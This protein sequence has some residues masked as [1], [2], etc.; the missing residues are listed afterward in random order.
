MMSI[1]MKR[2]EAL[3]WL[4]AG[5][6]LPA[7]PPALPDAYGDGTP[8]FLRLTDRP[9]QQAFRA[10]SCWLA[11]ALYVSQPSLPPEVSDCA[12]LLRFCFRE[13]LR[14]HDGAWARSLGLLELPP[15]G[16]VTPPRFPA[17]FLRDR[18]FRIR[19]G[20]FQERDI[21]DGAFRAFASARHLMLFN[22]HPAGRDL[23]LA[24]PG[25]LLFFEQLAGS[26]PFHSMLWTGDAAV[27]HTG[28]LRG[29]EGEIRRLTPAQLASHP[30]P[31]W[32]PLPGNQNFLGVYRWNILRDPT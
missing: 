15:I 13:S 30:E 5:R 7:G 19:P 1:L 2:R 31:R 25:D 32:R 16:D 26:L 14:R 22:A 23:R 27:Y 28:P 18:V 12:G 9:A 29:R 11:G 3:L 4:A 8:A 17:P 24:L 6:L 21:T 10:W 20:P